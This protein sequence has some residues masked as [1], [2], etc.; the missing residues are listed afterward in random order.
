[1]VIKIIKKSKRK[2]N[3]FIKNRR[4][5]ENRKFSYSSFF[6]K[7]RKG[8]VEIVEVFIAILLLMGV[9]F[10]VIESTSP[11]EDEISSKI[12]EREISILRDIE[13]NNTLRTEILSVPLSAL[14]VNW[15]EFSFSLPLVR[16]RIISLS[17]LDLEC[18]AKICELNDICAPDEFPEKSI[19]VKSLVISAN[20]NTYSPRQLKLYCIKG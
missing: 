6:P 11:K 10:V 7:N 12:Y 18:Q 2:C 19:Y 14:P 5:E 1:M 8:W 20:L 4:G 16:E 3:F 9:L 15:T 17:P 13:L